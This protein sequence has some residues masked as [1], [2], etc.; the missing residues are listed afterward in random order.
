[1]FSIVNKNL[2]RFVIRMVAIMLALLLV[3]CGGVGTSGDQPTQSPGTNQQEDT[4][5]AEVEPKDKETPEP[6]EQPD[7]PGTT[8]TAGESFGAYVEA[9]GEVLTIL[10]DALANNPGTELDTMSLLGVMMVDMTLLPATSFGLGEEVAIPMLEFLGAEGTAYSENDNQYSVKYKNSEGE[11]YELQGVFD[12]AA[13]ALKCTVL[14][15]G[16]EAVI[17]EY[18]KTSFG[19]VGQIYSVNEDGSL[20]MYQL[21]LSGSNG[22]V[23]IS[24][25]SVAPAALTGSEAADFPK[26]GKEWYAID[27]DTFTGVTSDGRELSFKYTPSDD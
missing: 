18:R 5:P 15:D 25:V 20:A 16:K 12:K 6:D 21:A 22:V 13:D 8:G 7:K 23:G 4:P 26:A 11:L 19:Y 1:M 27:G 2:K 17:S 10:S 14:L 9:K 24:E 3:G